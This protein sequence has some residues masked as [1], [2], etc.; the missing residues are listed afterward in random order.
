MVDGPYCTLPMR[1]VMVVM[2]AHIILGLMCASC[3]AQSD[4]ISSFLIAIGVVGMMSAQLN[5][6]CVPAVSS[7]RKL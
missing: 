7:C 2:S 3:F 1:C 4:A 5:L 6:V